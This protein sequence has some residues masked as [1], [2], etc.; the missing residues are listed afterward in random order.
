MSFIFHIV[1][2]GLYIS[3]LVK[4]E[5]SI[6]ITYSSSKYVAENNTSY[7][8][9]IPLYHHLRRCIPNYHHL[10]S[11]YNP[12]QDRRARLHNHMIR[13]HRFSPSYSVS[14]VFCV[15]IPL[16]SSILCFGCLYY[17]H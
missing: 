11:L 14:F 8:T 15:F 16:D 4:L 9:I 13:Y 10:Y 5:S 2:S 17:L 12:E 1:F 7:H 6:C 3:I